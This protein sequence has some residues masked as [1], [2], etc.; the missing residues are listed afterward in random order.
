MQFVLIGSM[1]LNLVVDRETIHEGQSLMVG[2]I[3]D[4]VVHKGHWKIVFGTGAIEIAKV[5]TDTDSA[6]FC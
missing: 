3:I 6:V 2:T 1:I 5:R 4:N